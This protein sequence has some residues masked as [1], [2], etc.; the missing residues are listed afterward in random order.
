MHKQL[1]VEAQTESYSYFSVQLPKRRGAARIGVSPLSF[2][3]APPSTPL[4]SVSLRFTF[5]AE[6]SSVEKASGVPVCVPATCPHQTSFFLSMTV[7]FSDRHPNL[8]V[9]HGRTKPVLCG[10]NSTE[11]NLLHHGETIYRVG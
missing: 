4:Q 5:E 10:P 7:A 6:S 3:A 2:S 9:V 8:Y 11:P 1:V